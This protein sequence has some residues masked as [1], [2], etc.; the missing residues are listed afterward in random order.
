MGKIFIIIKEAFSGRF[1]SL[2]VIAAVAISTSAFGLF[3]GASGK[4]SQYID[5]KFAAS[6]PPNTI[7][8]SP[9]PVKTFLFFTV[10]PDRSK[11]ITDAAI[12]R[13]SKIGGIMRIDPVLPL[14]VPA[15]AAIG[16]FGFSYRI[17]INALG[18][19]E[20]F[21]SPDVKGKE[22]IAFWRNPKH[23]TTVPVV[24]PRMIIQAYNDGM[25]ESNNLPRIS[26]QSA[27]G[28]KL[29]LYIGRSSIRKLDGY[30]ETDAAVAG[31]TDKLKA[32]ALPLPIDLVRRYNS[33]F[34]P[35]MP[36]E[37]S[38]LYIN[39]KDHESLVR[40]SKILKGW[41]YHTET[42]KSI[43][44]NIIRLKSAVESALALFKYIV[45]GLAAAAIYFSSLISVLNRLEYYRLLRA[46]GSSKLFIAFALAFKY[47][48]LGA[49]GSW[50]GTSLLA[51]IFE[52]SSLFF[53]EGG[54]IF[55]LTIS[56]GF[57]KNV[58]MYGIALPVL[59][60]LPA[61]ARLY[62]RDLSRD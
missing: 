8:V 5:N 30:I 33:K 2:M 47:A 20:R 11:I 35:G 62:S 39:V 23:E 57:Y 24:I 42:D 17:D 31:F 10:Q 59:S 32:L 60:I 44:E 16:M 14:K 12:T 36:N 3:E 38:A 22:N 27:A 9:P 48:L 40:V 54:I 37:Y 7:K 28:L 15:Q 43:S 45:L 26:E 18:V 13:V 41:G 25:A 49:A 19:S 55:Y 6:I 34:N 53:Q 46:L 50:A 58:F 1:V 4:F 29:K 52:K 51:L 56:E 21:L 61:L